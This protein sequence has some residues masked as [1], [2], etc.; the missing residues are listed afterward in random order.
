VRVV[1]GPAPPSEADREVLSSVELA[2]GWRLACALT[3][4][5]DLTV[6]VPGGTGAFAPKGFGAPVRVDP[7]RV[8]PVAADPEA[9]RPRVGLAVDIGT[10]SLAA[11]LVDLDA[12]TDMATGSLLNPQAE[13]GAD[14]MSRIHAA[15]QSDAQRRSLVSAVR[16]GIATLACGLLDEA[17]LSGGHVA[18]ATVVGNS[19]MLHLWYGEDPWSLGVAPYTGRWTAALHVRPQDVGLPIDPAARVYVFPCLRSHVGADAVSAAVAVGLD[20]VDAPA[21]LID[22]GTNSELVLGDGARILAASTA[23]GPAFECGGISCGMR[24]AEGAIDALRLEPD[25]HWSS[26]VIGG[27]PP[28]G[29]CGSGLLDAVAELLRVGVIEPSGYMRRADQARGT[30]PAAL[31]SRLSGPGDRRRATIVAAE[32]PAR[33]IALEA[34]DVR[35]LQLAT[36]AV[37]AGIEVLCAEAGLQ[38]AGLRTIFVAGTFGQYVRKSSLLRLGLLPPVA[39]ERVQTVGNAAGAGAVLALLDQRVRDRAERLA[40]SAIYVELAGRGDYQEAL[41]RS[42]RFTTPA[43]SAPR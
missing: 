13:F 25:G 31:L 19:A 17:G 5:G 10:T 18:A 28:R 30:V 20:A 15:G 42:L 43:G 34:A 39:P 21:L 24:A 16:R 2:D 37:R 36:G 27:V 11:A 41:T 32:E 22:L 4:C 23:A 35:Q 26:H 14:V 33:A 29:I 6:E 3:A 38:A 9:A 40:A 8:P 7:A 12:G 1:A